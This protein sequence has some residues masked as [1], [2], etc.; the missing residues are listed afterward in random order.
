MRTQ[1]RVVFSLALATGLAAGAT[2][3]EPY[4]LLL[5]GQEAENFLLTAKVEAR[6]TIS[7]GITAP[8]KLT[9]SDGTRTLH[10]AWKTINE[11]KLGLTSMQT[12][13]EFDFRDSWKSEVAA[14]KLDQ[15]LGLNLVPPTVERRIGGRVGSLMLWVEG[16]RTE[17]ER[18][19]A[20]I[21]APDPVAWNHQMYNVR[22][23]H[24]LTYDTDYRNINNVLSDPSF[25]IY[26]VD[27]SRAFRIQKELILAKEL[28]H[29]SRKTLQ[30]LEKL[31]KPTLKEA[32]GHW[33]EGMQI[34]GLL[35]RRD[36]ILQLAHKLVEEKGEDAVL[37][38]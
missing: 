9:L 23:L 26:A 19:K 28:T 5:Q 12:G 4:G 25:R 14:Y 36:L 31:D 6:K 34:D 7:T 32:M 37:Y 20:G 17:E 2:A 24:Q 10:A 11:H 22:I 13:T 8:Q 21:D 1:T 16:A 29:F 18:T 15:L 27:F 3:D 38:P 35:A 30:A 33:L